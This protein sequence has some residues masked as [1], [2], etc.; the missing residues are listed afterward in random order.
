MMPS[1]AQT[2]R[3]NGWALFAVVG[4]VAA[5]VLGLIGWTLY[6]FGPWE[7]LYRTMRLFGMDGDA[8]GQ[9]NAY[10]WVARFLAPLAMASGIVAIVVRVL[11]DSWSRWRA[12]RSNNHVVVLGGGPEAAEIAIRFRPGARVVCIGEV[13]A[14]DQIEL[15]AARVRWVEAVSETQ[16]ARV[17]DG[18]ITVIITATGD[19]EASSL[20]SRVQALCKERG[21]DPA[22]V[23]LVAS[24]D[25]ALD[26]RYTGNDRVVCRSEQVART[27]LWKRPPFDEHRVTPSPLVLGDGRLAAE[28][29]ARIFE[30]WQQPGE[31]ITVHC[32]GPDAARKY[33]VERGLDFSD[34]PGSVALRREN[35]PQGLGTLAWHELPAG[36]HIAPQLVESVLDGWNTSWRAYR[37]HGEYETAPLPVYIAFDDDAV[38]IPVAN[39]VKRALGD[40][41]KVV[42]VPKNHKLAE[43]L[44]VVISEEHEAPSGDDEARHRWE[45]AWREGVFL[46]SQTAMLCSPQELDRKLKDVLAKELESELKRWPDEVPGLFTPSGAPDVADGILVAVEEA[47]FSVVSAPLPL[48]RV[49]VLT[50]TELDRTAT[51]LSL[52]V[53]SSPNGVTPWERRTR[54]LELT[55]RL[56]AL[57]NRAGRAL[58]RSNEQVDLIPFDRLDHLAQM[59]HNDY[60][61]VAARTDNATGSEYAAAAYRQLPE[62]LRSSNVAQVLDIPVKLAL[63]GLKFVPRADTS[64]GPGTIAE[65]RFTPEDV[66]ILAYQEHRRWAHFQL[67]NGRSSHNWNIPWEVLRHDVREYDRNAVRGIPLLLREMDMVIVEDP[68]RRSELPERPILK[69]AEG[70]FWRI[71]EV[72]AER[73]TEP[74]S[75][76]A[77]GGEELHAEAGDW[78]VTSL[79]PEQPDGR[80]VRPEA[81]A[82]TYAPLDGDRY[83]RVGSVH[84]RQVMERERVETHE[85][86]AYAEPRD[87]VIRDGEAT[88]PVSEESFKTL[89]DTAPKKEASGSA[90]RRDG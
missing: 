88:W 54:L 12:I 86:T 44:C 81:F 71:G 51:A 36:T 83:E 19:Q 58:V 8:D 63:L 56:P 16:L 53:P 28:L 50:A 72:H 14:E 41:V 27:V 3:R 30:G 13:T 32:G 64:D 17:L 73:L 79:D 89:Y 24:H 7:A 42:V 26:W 10:L 39:A 43:H 11:H 34:S 22:V 38:A 23:T 35:G 49:T 70:R 5:F 9:I 48:R 67:R 61:E 21:Q 37:K 69:P 78:W 18:C 31:S 80:S 52:R 57:L 84:A 90:P 25:V 45:R 85:G 33:F 82:R 75:W 66:E 76:T 6:G 77:A 65:Y 62:L 4:F 1:I 47:G 55:G 60:K 2:L 87:W 59:V 40:R 74:R 46:Q 68:D 20:T 15:R 29:T